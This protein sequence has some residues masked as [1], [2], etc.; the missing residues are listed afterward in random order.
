[1]ALD[2]AM[3]SYE[4]FFQPN[5]ISISS[6]SQIYFTLKNPNSFAYCLKN[7]SLDTSDWKKFE[8]KDHPVYDKWMVE[9]LAIYRYEYDADLINSANV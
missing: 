5:I 9:D 4:S 8:E 6:L 3:N 2:D 7:S 1:M